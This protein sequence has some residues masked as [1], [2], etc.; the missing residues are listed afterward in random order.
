MGQG[1][2]REVVDGNEIG[3]QVRRQLRRLVFGDQRLDQ[4][5]FGHLGAALDAQPLR[6][7]VQVLLGGPGVDPAGGL[8]LVASGGR[9]LSVVGTG[10][11]LVA[12]R[13]RAYAVVDPIEL[14]GLGTLR[15]WS[16]RRAPL[17]LE[18]DDELVY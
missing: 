2:E 16:L 8:A 14:P 18:G 5:V 12:A 13:E 4:L 6:L 9:V 15:P 3:G 7:L 1:R 10:P 11:D 17:E